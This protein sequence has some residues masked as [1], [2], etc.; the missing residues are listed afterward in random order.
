MESN[1][2]N[3]MQLSLFVQKLHQFN[4]RPND[5][6]KCLNNALH[7]SISFGH[8]LEKTAVKYRESLA[9]S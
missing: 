2:E 3:P 5:P 9:G 7:N 1:G 4:C 6:L 8:C